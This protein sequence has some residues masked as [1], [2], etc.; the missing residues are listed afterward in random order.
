MYRLDEWKIAEI[1]VEPETAVAV[2]GSLDVHRRADP[3]QG[4]LSKAGSR[5]QGG[6]VTEVEREE[7]RR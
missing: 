6:W 5:R 4:D 1:G 2:D 3:F 7:R